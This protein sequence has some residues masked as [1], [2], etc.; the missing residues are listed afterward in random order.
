MFSTSNQGVALGLDP[1]ASTPHQHITLPSRATTRPLHQPDHGTG[2]ACPGRSCWPP[3][4][5]IAIDSRTQRR[6]GNHARCSLVYTTLLRTH[7]PRLV[8]PPP[9][10]LP[11][12][13][14]LWAPCPA[15]SQCSL[16]Y[17]PVHNLARVASYCARLAPDS[18]H[19]TTT[20]HKNSAERTLEPTLPCSRNLG[21]NNRLHVP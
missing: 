1:M 17:C 6:D 2:S 3:D 10:A 13:H 7:V 9:H 11:R 21:L 16:S 5:D 4:Q 14:A 19:A 18:A 20:P 12:R 8:L 15:P